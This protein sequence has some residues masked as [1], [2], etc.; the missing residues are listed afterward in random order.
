MLASLLLLVTP[1]AASIVRYD[2]TKA[3]QATSP[4]QYTLRTSTSHGL[5]IV[6]LELPRK[7]APLDHLWR[8]DVQVRKNGKLQL[9]A[10]LE[11]KL[12][13]DLL[14][15]DLLLDPDAMKDTEI[16][17]RTGEHAPLAET[18]YAIDVGS[19]KSP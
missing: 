19:F 7:Q 17:I 9:G 4:V 12:D 18:V 10:P 6:A 8:I 1:A 11:T 16:W 3:N 5:V 15:T 13:G 14:K 2:L